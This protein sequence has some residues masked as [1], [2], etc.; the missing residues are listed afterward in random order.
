MKKENSRIETKKKKKKRFIVKKH[1]KQKLL[2]QINNGKQIEEE[3]EVKSQEEIVHPKILNLLKKKLSAYQINILLRC[4]KFSPTPKRNIKSDIHNY[5]WKLSL[6]KFF[7][8]V[9]ENDNL[10]NFFKTKS[11][12]TPSR[13]RDKDLDH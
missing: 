7:H 8:N 13:N 6:T 11:N 4:L 12:F 2:K 10:L 1:K 9:S 5:T 3:R